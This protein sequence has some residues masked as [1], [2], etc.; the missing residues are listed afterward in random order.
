[1][2][3]KQKQRLE[4]VTF[5]IGGNTYI[6]AADEQKGLIIKDDGRIQDRQLVVELVKEWVQAVINRD[7]YNFNINGEIILETV[8]EKVKWGQGNTSDFHVA[9][10]GQPQQ[11]QFKLALATLE[12][13]RPYVDDIKNR[14]SSIEAHATV[15]QKFDKGKAFEHLRERIDRVFEEKVLPKKIKESAKNTEEKAKNTGRTSKVE[16]KSA[17]DRARLRQ[18]NID[19]KTRGLL[20]IKNLPPEYDL[21]NE[22]EK[23]A[24]TLSAEIEKAIVS[25]GV[26]RTDATTAMLLH[27]NDLVLPDTINPL[28]KHK[29]YQGTDKK[30]LF[31][32]FF[33][34]CQILENGMPAIFLNVETKQSAQFYADVISDSIAK[35]IDGYWPDY[36][37]TPLIKLFMEANRGG[38]PGLNP[39]RVSALKY[40]END[41]KKPYTGSM[42]ALMATIKAFLKDITE[43][44]TQHPARVITDIQQEM[45]QVQEDG[46]TYATGI[47][48]V[49]EKFK[50]K[51]PNLIPFDR[52]GLKAVLPGLIRGAF[53]H[54]DDI[55]KKT[56]KIA[57]TMI[58]ITEKVMGEYLEKCR[59]RSG[60]G[61]QS[62][63]L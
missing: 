48:E 58:K 62:R 5:F 11:Q 24:G 40:V 53:N 13:L 17:K 52:D 37:K 60:K 63:T 39:F 41:Y 26:D 35:V 12:T 30:D 7:H 25:L 45:K 16:R 29:S 21:K 47:L 44:Y 49:W 42:P 55:D 34:C 31:G 57:E 46:R 6:V 61:G 15:D 50:P 22:L 38:K 28:F 27:F 4:P 56:D 1:M 20:P 32:E 8:E 23:L 43:F 10:A 51:Y 59:G 33:S 54:L 36:S 19:R 9:F 2:D 18:R 3:D 14:K